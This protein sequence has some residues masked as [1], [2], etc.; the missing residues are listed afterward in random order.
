MPRYY[1]PISGQAIP[2]TMIANTSKNPTRPIEQSD[3]RKSPR[4]PLPHVGVQP[5]PPIDRLTVQRPAQPQ[6]RVTKIVAGPAVKPGAITK[7]VMDE[8]CGPGT[9]LP[10]GVKT[11]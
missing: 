3:N 4:G 5:A 11:R 8:D 1:D 6:Q 2:E 9:V 7:A 10:G